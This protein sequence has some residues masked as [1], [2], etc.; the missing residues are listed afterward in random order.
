MSI[1]L[2]ASPGKVFIDFMD[3]EQTLELTTEEAEGFHQAIGDM[4]GA[5]GMPS[6]ASQDDRGEAIG[7]ELIPGQGEAPCASS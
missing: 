3:L 2:R 4:I 6:P 7:V 5:A 1:G